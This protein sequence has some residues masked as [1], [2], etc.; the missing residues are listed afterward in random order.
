M[1]NLFLKSYLPGHSLHYWTLFKAAIIIQRTKNC[2]LL[3]TVKDVFW[4]HFFP[5]F[6]CTK[7]EQ[8]IL[9]KFL[10][11]GVRNTAFRLQSEV[12]GLECNAPGLPSFLEISRLENK[13]LYTLDLLTSF[14]TIFSR[15][16]AAS[17]LMTSNTTSRVVWLTHSDPSFWFQFHLSLW[18]GKLIR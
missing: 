14:T 3:R 5:A 11:S 2:P 7:L 16:I 9:V 8:S 15:N 12:Y 1:V 17:E 6:D 13:L 18:A 10:I 4:E